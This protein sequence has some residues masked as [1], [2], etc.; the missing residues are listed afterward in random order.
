MKIINEGK[1]EQSLK[2]YYRYFICRC[3]NHNFN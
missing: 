1:Y 3:Y 2:D